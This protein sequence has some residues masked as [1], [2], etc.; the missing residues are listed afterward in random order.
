MPASAPQ[1]PRWPPQNLGTAP[2]LGAGTSTLSWAAGALLWAYVVLLGERQSAHDEN[3]GPSLS[4]AESTIDVGPF[5]Q[6]PRR[7]AF[8][9]LIYKKARRLAP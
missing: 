6:S 1:N 4:C 9:S 5:R 3:V 2:I 7:R 8:W